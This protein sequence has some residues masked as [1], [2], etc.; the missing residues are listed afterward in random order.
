MRHLRLATVLGVAL[1]VPMFT[2]GCLTTPT[3]AD[4]VV[5]L[6]T[7]QSVTEGFTADGTNNITVDTKTIDINNEI[8]ISDALSNAG[9]DVSDVS[10]ISVSNVAYRITRG[11]TNA[12]D[13]TIDGNVQVAC[14]GHA[15]VGLI[16]HFTGAAGAP[17]DWT[18]PVLNSAG[19]GQIN[20]LLADLLTQVKGGATANST[21]TYTINGVSSPTSVATDFDYELRLTINIVGK[22]KT[23][24]LTGK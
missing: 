17:T 4:R 11:D 16:D 21:L 22:V 6:V 20:A 19:V 13:R 2:S 8:N 18:Y 5:D 7:T 15:S 14:Q 1:L 10:S 3:I 12:A 9:I 23:K 24:I